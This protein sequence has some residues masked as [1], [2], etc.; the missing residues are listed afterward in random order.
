ML[1]EQNRTCRWIWKL[2]DILGMTA[3][4]ERRDRRRLRAD[5][6]AALTGQFGYMEVRGCD[7]SRQGIGVLAPDAVRPDALVFVRLKDLGLSGF[8]HVRRCDAL[9][10]GCF[11][12]GLQFRGQ[13]SR[14]R[15]EASAW[16]QQRLTHTDGVWDASSEFAN[17]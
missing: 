15:S 5:F 17:S 14:E 4:L 12:L 7:A 3:R 1:H 16:N 10:E 6:R 9:P 13:L 11:R 8:A 2:A